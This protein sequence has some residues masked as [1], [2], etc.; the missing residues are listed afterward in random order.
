MEKIEIAAKTENIAKSA[1]I[2][3]FLLMYGSYLEQEAS[4]FFQW[5]AI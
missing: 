5:L 3:L 2:W 1:I 4:Y